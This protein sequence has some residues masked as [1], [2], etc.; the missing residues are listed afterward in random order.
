[1]PFK[2]RLNLRSRFI[3]ALL[4]VATLLSGGYY[5]AVHEFIEVLE[6][7]LGTQSLIRELNAFT[8]YYAKNPAAQP[9]ERDRI[10]TYVYKANEAATDLPP[11]LAKW[12]NSRSGE[13]RWHGVEYQAIRHDIGDTRV[14]MTLS[15]SRVEDLERRLMAFAWIFISGALLMSAIVGAGL[16]LLVTRPVSRLA[17]MVTGLHPAERGNKLADQ[18]GDH[19]VGLIAQAFDQY[20]GKI[21]EYVKRE[22]AFTDDA[23]HELRTPLTIII[24]A[25]QLLEEDPQLG[26]SGRERLA[27][28]CRAAAQMQALIE[29]LLFLAREDG[30]VT[31]DRCA[32]H[33][34]LRESVDALS[35]ELAGKPLQIRL[36]I[37]AQVVIDAPRAMV[38]CVVRNLIGNA[39]QH[40]GDGRIEVQ[41]HEREFIVQDTGSGIPENALERIFERR[42]RGADSH[43]LGLGLYI[44]QRICKR[45]GWKIDACNVEGSGARFAV[46]FKP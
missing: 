24:N 26:A 37:G 43:G 12:E 3:L 40:G 1:M 17:D 46:R 21:D 16:S 7:E 28:I 41:L 20:L 35:E 23:S 13:F 31:N 11:P 30:G 34:I 4:V 29:A 10:R 8:E 39:I 2:P 19:E 22:K 32:M 44:V 25:A 5:Y 14:Y 18:F 33:E 42:Y 27:R 45:L 15:L 36:D 9:I 38:S 6:D